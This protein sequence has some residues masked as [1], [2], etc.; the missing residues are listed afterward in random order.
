MTKLSKKSVNMA[1]SHNPHIAA[2]KIAITT[3]YL[4][5]GAAHALRDYFLHQQ[6]PEEI[7]FITLPLASQREAKKVVYRDGKKVAETIYERSRNEFVINYF[8]DFF[9]TILWVVSSKRRYDVFFGFGVLNGF[10]GVVL[11]KVGLIKKTIFYS[12]DFVPKRFKNSIL[13]LIYHKL[14]ALCVYYSDEVW[15]VSPRMAKGRQDFLGISKSLYVRKVVPIGVWNKN[16]SHIPFSKIKLYEI[17]FIGHLLE[18][19]GVQEV[20]RAIP[21]IVKK[22]PNFSFLIIGGGE[23]KKT[24]EE[25]VNKFN[26]K[27]YVIFKGWIKNREK[28]DKILGKSAAA[29][30]PYKPE[31]EKLY[32]FTYY[33]DPTKIKDYLAAGLPIILTDVSYN[34]QEI[35]QKSCGFVIEYDSKA[36]AEAIIRLLSKKDLLKKYRENARN[37][38][39]TFD[40][41]AIF[42]KA[43]Y[44]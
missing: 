43:F 26:I 9:L 11:K 10:S 30:A 17:V 8:L 33:A 44:E 20:L 36:I 13:N 14:E 23:Y 32:N 3:H 37:Y 1:T 39:K 29:V 25:M 2:S 31:K 35:E 6:G 38:A 41:N 18:K 12:I 19:Q 28:I 7:L 24:L 42:L 5:Y 21:N 4:L 27:K 40:W 22:I 16:I 15:D 34:A